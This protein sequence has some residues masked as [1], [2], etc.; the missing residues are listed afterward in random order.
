MLDLCS[1]QKDYQWKPQQLAFNYIWHSPATESGFITRVFWLSP[2][3]KISAQ[4]QNILLKKDLIAN[5]R[6]YAKIGISEKNS[7]LELGLNF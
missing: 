7:Y 3:K 5:R 2:L 6:Q 1:T 4:V